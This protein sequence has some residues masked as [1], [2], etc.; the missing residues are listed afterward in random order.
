M[1]TLFTLIATAALLAGP[2]MAGSQNETS[3]HPH[4]GWNHGGDRGDWRGD[5]GHRGDWRGDRGHRDRP[6]CRI[7]FN[8]FRCHAAEAAE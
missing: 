4:Q 7:D 1:K 2:A 6:G 5:R 3:W 8:G